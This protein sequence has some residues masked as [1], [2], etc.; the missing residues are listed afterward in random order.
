MVVLK[1]LPDIPLK[2]IV[3]LLDVNSRKN[4]LAASSK[5]HLGLRLKSLCTDRRYVCPECV[6]TA[7]TFNL[8]D[9]SEKLGDLDDPDE[10][11][12]RYHTSMRRRG[13]FD[14]YS[15]FRMLMSGNLNYKMEVQCVTEDEQLIYTIKCCH[16]KIED[17]KPIHYFDT[18]YKLSDFS[19][20]RSNYM[21]VL[22]S[23]R[24]NKELH[25]AEKQKLCNTFL[26]GKYKD[27]TVVSRVKLYTA[28]EFKSHISRRHCTNGLQSIRDFDTWVN[29]YGDVNNTFDVE[30]H[31]YFN[32]STLDIDDYDDLV[33]NII[34]ARYY[35]SITDD[36]E[37]ASELLGS[38]KDYL[39]S[40]VRRV[41]KIGR[42]SFGSLRFNRKCSREN[43][44]TLL[45][46]YDVHT[47]V[48]DS[49]YQ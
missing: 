5:S 33:M 36:L 8:L 4:L 31:F 17:Y 2:K 1:N 22:K 15:Q 11:N 6:I 39:M 37:I 40:Q 21:D 12:G 46:F 34:T 18:M 42:E 14:F 32:G 13:V 26:G 30:N 44:L 24:T 41:F 28:D 29:K 10:K 20:F 25:D 48:F 27:T 35:N 43:D 3:E 9:L 47:K 23:V 45:K 19:Y 7:G 16:E 38:N 49:I